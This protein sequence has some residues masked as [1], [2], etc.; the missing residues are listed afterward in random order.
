MKK[1]FR[2]PLF[3]IILATVLVLTALGCCAAYEN[4]HVNTGDTCEDIIAVAETQLGYM[5]GSLEGTVQKYDDCTKYG[6]WYG[7]NYNPWCAMFVSWCADQAGIPTTV[8]PKHASCDVGMQWFISKGIFEYSPYYG[9]S[10]TPKRGD[11]IYFGY[12]MNTGEFDSNHVGI[13]YKV[14][15]SRVYVYEG[16]SSAKVQSVFYKLGDNSYIL[17]YGKPTY[18]GAVIPDKEVGSYL[19]NTAWLNFRSEPNASSEKLE[20]L[21]MNTVLKITEISK[22]ETTGVSWGK[23]TYNGKTGWVSLDYCVRAY[24]ISYSAEGATD[25]PNPQYKTQGATLNLST[26]IPKKSSLKFLGW[27]LAPNTEA[28][29]KP[30]DS[31][32]ENADTVLYAVWESEPVYKSYTIKYNANGGTMAPAAQTKTEKIDIVLSAD[33]PKRDGYE[34]LGWALSEKGEI[35]YRPSDIYKD[36]ADL[37]LYAQWKAVAVL[38]EYTIVYD[39]NGGKN[40]PD[41]Q[42]KTEGIDII[43]SSQIP[44]R[45]G[46]S[47]EGWAKAASSRWYDYLPGQSYTEENSATLYALWC[48]AVPSISIIAGN[49]G[50]TSRYCEGNTLY[51]KI[52]ADKGFSVSAIKVNS[53]PMPLVGDTESTVITLDV[54]ASVKVD[55]S[56]TDNSKLWINPFI[57]VKDSDWFYDAAHYCYKNKIITGVNETTFAPNKTLTRGEFVTILGRVYESSGGVIACNGTLPFTDISD[58]GYYYTYLCWAYN[59]KIVSGTSATR[60]SPADPLTRE[61]MCVMLYNYASFTG[62]LSSYNETLIY[63]YKDNEDISSWAKT[64]M[65]WAISRRVISGYKDKLTP[66]DTATRSQAATVIMNFSSKEK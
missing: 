19:I 56:F 65:G 9:G 37:T 13:V 14:E 6:E 48:K 45:E 29:Y 34:F 20:L 50:R 42:K 62:K 7:L 17:G 54:S 47:F 49:G 16:N 33:I 58:K 1:F 2:I 10:Y 32:K 51:L 41:S 43:L 8:I 64:A 46:Y 21:A 36:D 53:V 27:A 5:E 11:I 18:D 3:I 66:K 63:T 39:A 52:I 55:I 23:A 44:V 60:F 22:N 15:N 25:I 31:F 40:A 4:T 38:G 26:Q 12:R 30:G 57:D 28:V 35:K 61:Q 24:E 59:N